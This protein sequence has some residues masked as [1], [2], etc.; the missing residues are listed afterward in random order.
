MIMK[1]FTILAVT[2]IM[3]MGVVGL[4]IF[5]SGGVVATPSNH[6]IEL[7]WNAP[8]GISNV[9]YNINGTNGFT[10]T[11][12]TSTSYTIDNL[13]N[14]TLYTYTVTYDGTE[15]D[16][17]VEGVI[18]GTASAKPIYIE[19]ATSEPVTTT[20]PVVTTA[21]V[22][23]ASP[24]VTA[25]PTET[26]VTTTAPV[27]TST[28]TATNTAT[29][30]ATETPVVTNTT[31]TTKPT[32]DTKYAKNDSSYNVV[33]I[34]AENSKNTNISVTIGGKDIT[35]NQQ[36]VKGGSATFTQT[37]S[38]GKSFKKSFKVTEGKNVIY[39]KNGQSYTF[40]A[41]GEDQTIKDADTKNIV[42]LG[43]TGSNSGSSV[44]LGDVTTSKLPSNE[45]IT[46]LPKTGESSNTMLIFTLAGSILVFGGIAFMVKKKLKNN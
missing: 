19:P 24:V 13:T 33:T 17:A 30:T 21:T 14:G 25:T 7:S 35:T 40:W 44:D 27:T 8:S 9:T 39:G 5:A 32:C 29:S 2:I 36:I 16:A 22:T 1:K 34:N 23:T 37:L 28:V 45:L 10:K 11:G 20:A 18:I 26:P 4:N 31:N 3:I 41:Y 43:S 46:T 38:N 42:Y 15:N 12:L 6:Q